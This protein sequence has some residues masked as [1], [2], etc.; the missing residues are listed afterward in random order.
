M[1]C[2]RPSTALQP[3]LRHATPA[4]CEEILRVVA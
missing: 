1:T 4:Y 2:L 3:S